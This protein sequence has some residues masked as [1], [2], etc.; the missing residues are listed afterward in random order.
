MKRREKKQG[1]SPLKP[2]SDVGF[3]G[4]AGPMLCTQGAAGSNPAVF[5]IAKNS[6]HLSVMN[7]ARPS[8]LS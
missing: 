1:L 2:A 4:P 8:W 7:V 6:N 3:E 5:T